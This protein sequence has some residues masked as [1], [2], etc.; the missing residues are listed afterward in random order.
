VPDHMLHLT[1]V[2]IRKLNL[3]VIIIARR[4]EKARTSKSDLAASDWWR[5]RSLICREW[6]FAVGRG[7]PS[8]LMMM[9]MMMLYLLLT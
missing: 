4:L 6:D 7:H 2:T 8:V 9:I 5:L 1:V 3:L